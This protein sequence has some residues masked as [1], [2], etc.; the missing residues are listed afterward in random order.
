MSRS[1]FVRRD[2]H[3]ANEEFE[4][5][6]LSNHGD[7]G[8]GNMS[9]RIER[10]EKKVDA[11]ESNLTRLNASMNS[12]ESK[13]ELQSAKFTGALELQSSKLSSSLELQSQKLSAA[14]DLQSQKLASSIDNQS[15]SFDGKLKDQRIAITLWVLGLPSV[16]Y[17]LYRIIS[18]LSTTSN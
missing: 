2:S 11:I 7:G 16:I 3:V 8:G 15:L 5:H 14:L 12:L 17:G 9:D 13:I 1:A 18:L 6:N 10:L 4:V